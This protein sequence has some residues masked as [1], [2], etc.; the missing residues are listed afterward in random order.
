[1][2]PKPALKF[3]SFSDFWPFYVSQHLVPL[4]RALHFVGTTLV[5]VILSCSVLLANPWIIIAVPIV[6]YGFAW[7]SHFFVE[8]NRPATFG[9]PLWSLQADFKMWW[10]MVRGKM[11]GEVMRVHGH[12]SVRKRST[13]S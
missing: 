1:M 11:T 9:H 3:E 6:G 8:G 7:P 4:T 10:F 5:I 2:L 12:E 13:D